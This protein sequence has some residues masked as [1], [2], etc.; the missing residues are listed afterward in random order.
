MGI[1]IKTAASYNLDEK[2]TKFDPEEYA[3]H[4]LMEYVN[5]TI[6]RS[7]TCDIIW[8]CMA[9]RFLKSSEYETVY[10]ML[11]SINNDKVRADTIRDAARRALNDADFYLYAAVWDASRHL[12]RQRDKFAHHCFGVNESLPNALLLI[13]AKIVARLMFFEPD[14]FEP[15]GTGRVRR[16]VP[17]DLIGKIGRVHV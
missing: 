7:A 3:G 1:K 16:S 10:E 6:G 4:P 8:N 11:R 14:A 9:A 2:E 5:L 13:D 17:D 15:A 12:S